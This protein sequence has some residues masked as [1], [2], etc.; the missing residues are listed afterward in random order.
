[1][2]TWGSVAIKIMDDDI[3]DK[4]HTEIE[5]FKIAKI[6]GEEWKNMTEKQIASYEKVAKQK[7]KSIR[8]KWRFKTKDDKNKKKEEKNKKV[9][10]S[11]K[12][13][14]PVYC[15]LIFTYPICIQFNIEAHNRN[16]EGVI[17]REA[18]NQQC[19]S[20]CSHFGKVE[21]TLPPFCADCLVAEICAEL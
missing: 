15:F 12:P 9:V 8:K 13:K 10:D 18:R 5:C 6:I 4:D 1:M 2:R 7:N 16:Q 21:G 17:K 3:V 19:P 14:R 20:Q 11:N